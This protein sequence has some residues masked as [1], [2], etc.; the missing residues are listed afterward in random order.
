MYS[1]IYMHGKYEI[2][3]TKASAIYSEK[4]CHWIRNK[5]K[6]SILRDIDVSYINIMHILTIFHTYPCLY[7]WKH[8][9]SRGEQ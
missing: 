6:N 8:V 4:I 2:S 5:F 9:S 3:L 1:C 7:H